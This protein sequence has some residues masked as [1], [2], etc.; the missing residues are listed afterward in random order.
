LNAAERQATTA[1]RA[2]ELAEQRAKDL[3]GKLDDA[4]VKLAEVASIVFTRDKELADL[5][6]TMK[7]CEQVFYNMG[8]KDAEN[9]AE[10]VVFQAWKF[11]FTEG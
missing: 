7:N 5:K 2:Q 4:K 6:K 10:A 11:K 3:Q 9:L 8:F 1:E